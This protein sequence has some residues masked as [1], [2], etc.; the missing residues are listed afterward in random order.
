MKILLF[1]ILIL[2]FWALIIEPYIITVKKIKIQD[3]S[4]AGLK[5][6]FATDFHYKKY[7][8][9]RLKRDVK[10]I[11]QQNP[12]I[13]LLGGDFVNGH[14]QG[15]ALNHEIIGMEFGKLRSKHGTFAVL[16]NHDVWQDAAGISESLRK[17]NITV[18]KNSNAKSGPIYIAGVEDLQTQKPDIEKALKNTS[19]PRILLTHTPDVI[20]EVPKTVNLT[21]AGHLHGGQVNFP[22]LGAVTTPSKYGTKYAY[23]LFDVNGRKMFVSKGIG[24]SILPIRFLCPPQ[25]VVF[26][27]FE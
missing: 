19:A 13:I 25:I 2:I 6:V 22:F 7:E 3:K 14:R 24:T 10:K 12:D 17:N 1:F 15:N 5:I 26:E 16:G 8:K 27:F 21:L 11:N 20:E 18:L 23:G 9:F 4:L